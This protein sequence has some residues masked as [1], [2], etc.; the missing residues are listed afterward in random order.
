M[1]TK[2][3][4]LL[5]FRHA[6]GALICVALSVFWSATGAQADT[7]RHLLLSGFKAPGMIDVALKRLRAAYKTLGIEIA[8]NVTT[9]SRALVDSASGRTDGEVVRA[10]VIEELYPSLL[11][12]E[13]PLFT[14]STYAYGTSPDLADKPLE[15][16]KSL[17]AGYVRGAV[18]AEQTT[19]DYAETWQAE[20]L[21]QLFAMLVQD[22]LDLVIA[23]EK[24]AKAMI[25]KSDLTGK[26]FA[27]SSSRRDYDFFHYLHEK[28]ADL[29]SRIEEVLKRQSP[30]WFTRQPS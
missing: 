27:V 29:V 24:P 30:G 20:T 12:V 25:E 6:I 16:L 9:P 7:S 11:R 19:R 2:T 5:K 26:V 21:E 4:D 23:I 17:R 13:V 28:N 10:D 14:V 18:F 22:R 8:V 3:R 1:T 15:D